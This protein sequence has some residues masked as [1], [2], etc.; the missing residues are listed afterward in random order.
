MGEASSN[1]RDSPLA[2]F[3]FG[4]GGIIITALGLIQTERPDVHISLVIALV[5]SGGLLMILGFGTMIIE[6][7]KRVM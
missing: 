2:S 1:V 7:I 4:I 3:L 6:L 5:A